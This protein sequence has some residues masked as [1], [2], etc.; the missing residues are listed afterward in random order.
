MHFASDQPEQQPLLPMHALLSLGMPTQ[1]AVAAVSPDGLRL[2][3]SCAEL[4][5]MLVPH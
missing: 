1:Q 3:L 5:T 4:L 2:Q